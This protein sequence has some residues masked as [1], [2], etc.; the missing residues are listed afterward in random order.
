LYLFELLQN[1]VDDGASYVKFKEFDKG[2]VFLHNGRG[3]TPIDVLGL[4]SV[5]LSTKA[6][7]KKSVGFMGIGFKAVYK[8]FARVVVYDSTWSFVFEEPPTTSNV[9]SV[10]KPSHAWVMEP[11]WTIESRW[12]SP[13]SETRYLFFL[14]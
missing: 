7:D 1:A 5:G 6:T 13:S 8:R 4:A 12:D 10:V 2:I 3:F 9:A 14:I 11:K